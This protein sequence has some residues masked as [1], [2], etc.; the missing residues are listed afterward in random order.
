M[1]TRRYLICLQGGTHPEGDEYSLVV[2]SVLA[3]P[4][5]TVVDVRLRDVLIDDL[6]HHHKPL[7]QEVSLPRS[8]RGHRYEV[9]LAGGKQRS[10]LRS[11]SDRGQTEVIVAESV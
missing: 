2:L 9:S 8:N 10:S 3:H 1:S 6:R 5:V 11:Q 7:R 4:R